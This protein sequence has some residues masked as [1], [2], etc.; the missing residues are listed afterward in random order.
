MKVFISLFVFLLFVGNTYAG[1]IDTFTRVVFLILK[2]RKVQDMIKEGRWGDL[3]ITIVTGVII[4]LVFGALLSIG[5]EIWT[6]NK[7]RQKKQNS[8]EKADPP[9]DAE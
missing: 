6:W 7:D 4:F 8:V 2:N 1:K 9:K 5:C 3:L